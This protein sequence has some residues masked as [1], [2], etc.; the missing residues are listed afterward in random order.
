MSISSVNQYLHFSKFHLMEVTL[1]ATDRFV[2]NFTTAGGAA[3]VPLGGPVTR[4]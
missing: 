4:R 1:H 2:I 3:H